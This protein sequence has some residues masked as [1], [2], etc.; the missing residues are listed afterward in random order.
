MQDEKG[1]VEGEVD[2]CDDDGDSCRG[3]C[4][5]VPHL[6]GKSML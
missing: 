5:R 1:D 2:G 3:E 4:E 6:G